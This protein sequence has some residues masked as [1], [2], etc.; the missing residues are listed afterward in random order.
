MVLPFALRNRKGDNF[1]VFFKRPIVIK[2]ID[3]AKQDNEKIAYILIFCFYITID[4]LPF[5]LSSA[6]LTRQMNLLC[7]S[8]N[9]LHKINKC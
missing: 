5:P 4:K 6:I 9:R 3:T 1:T 7:N 8:S 2:Y